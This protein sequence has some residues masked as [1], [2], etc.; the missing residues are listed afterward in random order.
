MVY[1]IGNRQWRPHCIVMIHIG[2]GQYFDPC[3]EHK[4]VHFNDITLIYKKGKV[5]IELKNNAHE[6]EWQ[7]KRLH[8]W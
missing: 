4:F 1:G 6:P 8:T 5:T 3:L 7:T 2:M